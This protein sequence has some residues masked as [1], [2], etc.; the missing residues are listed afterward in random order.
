MKTLA[1]IATLLF[2]FYSSSL[3]AAELADYSARYTA[4][5]NG[6]KASAIRTLALTSDGLYQLSN[7]LVAEFAGTELASLDESTVFAVTDSTLQPQSYSYVLRG[8]GRESK[9]IVFDW[10][11]SLAS[12]SEDSDSWTLPLAANT[13]DP[14]SYQAALQMMLAQD[15]PTEVAVPIID[16]D[17]IDVQRFRIEGEEVLATPVGLLNC[18]RLVRVRDDDA[19]STTIWLAKD[20]NFLLVKIEQLSS[21]VSIVLELES[22]VVDGEVV[23]GQ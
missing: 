15:G 14:L 12:S 19:K 10:D 4:S 11:A 5:A 9:A 3:S 18:S 20:W 1:S 13:Q 2:S 7:R 22:A 23:V 21:G 16:G 17:K 8:L 6:L